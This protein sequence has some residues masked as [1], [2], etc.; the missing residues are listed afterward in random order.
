MTNWNNPQS[1]GISDHLRGLKKE[2][3]L[4]PRIQSSL[5]QLN[6]TVSSLDYK[7][8]T[9]N[10]KDAKLFNRIVMA[11]K[12]HD[13]TTGKVL[14]NELAELRKN[15]KIL[16]TMKVS[17]EQVNLRLSTVSDLGD[18]MSSLGPIMAT[19]NALKPA[20]GK[21]MPEV[22]REFESLFGILNDSVSSSFE[23]SF[24]SDTVSNEETENILKEAAAVAGTR[25]GD[26]FPSIPTGISSSNSIGLQ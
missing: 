1:K 20:L 6:R 19:M 2:A 5:V 10:E 7:V 24:G 14:A 15:K 11:K 22:S 23:G 26:K 21:I 25:V 12:S 16:T 9:L 13:I 17:L 4:K 8:K 18:A 3:P